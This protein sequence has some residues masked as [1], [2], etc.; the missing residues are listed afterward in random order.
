MTSIELLSGPFNSKSLNQSGCQ[1]RTARRRHDAGA[2]EAK[3]NDGHRQYEDDGGERAKT[4]RL[5]LC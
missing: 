2:S 1:H 4:L 5:S 3:D